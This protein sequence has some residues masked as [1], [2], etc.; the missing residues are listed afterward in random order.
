VGKQGVK[1]NYHVIIYTG[2]ELNERRREMLAQGE[3]GMLQSIK[4]QPRSEQ[5]KLDSL[6]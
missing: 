5:D 3:R 4:V 1:K 6:S 2:E